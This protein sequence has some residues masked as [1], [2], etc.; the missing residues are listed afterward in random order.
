MGDNGRT[1]RRDFLRRTAG[2]ALS[3]G[4]ASRLAAQEPRREALPVAGIITV[5][6]D[7]SHADVILGKILAGFDQKGGPGPALKLESLYVDQ[8]HKKDMSR[9]LANKYGFKIAGTI[10]EAL[11]GGTGRMQVA[12]VLSIGEHGDYPYTPDTKQHMYP[13][14]RF[15]DGIVDT[16]RRV[17]QV[18]PVFNDKHFAYRW[19]DAQAMYDTATKMKIP[20]MAGSSIPVAWRR[21]PLVLPM[22]CEIEQAFALGYGGLES[23][24][25]HALEGLQCM[26]E[27]R[28]GGET[29]VAAI[30]TLQGDEIRA[31]RERGEWSEELFAAALKTLPGA[32]MGDLSRL[33]KEAAFY[34]I[35]YRDGLK[36]T[37]AMT[38]GIANQFGFAARLRGQAEP[39]ATW[40][41]LEEGKP[42]GH[43]GHLVRAIEHMVHT[44]QP[45]Y[46]A[47][48]TLLTTGVLDAVMHSLADGGRRIET[49]ELKIAYQPTDW[50]FANRGSS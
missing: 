20:L 29:G 38:N 3:A 35:E 14:R 9:D 36:A 10:D 12:G 13:R 27:R 34:Q 32:P 43:F 49:P 30:R 5:Y 28:K 44:G 23:Y 46:P 50:T 11:T 7:N 24:G 41:E 19:S 31:A 18:V 21:P 15:F 37:V 2:M 22:G 4:F 47:E 45:A 39:V 26:V 17:G 40:Y 8:F 6:H 25:F 48:R 16:F 42:F 1:G 33:R